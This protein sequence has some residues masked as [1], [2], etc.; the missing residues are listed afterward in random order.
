MTPT[1]GRADRRRNRERLIEA[2]AEVFRR[3]GPAAPLE[4]IARRAGVGSATLHRH[5]GS[6]RDLLEAVCADGI[7]QLCVRAGEFA[8]GDGDAAADLWGWLDELVRFASATRGVVAVLLT[9]PE[10]PVCHSSRLREVAGPLRS[11]AAAAGAVHPGATVDD[12]LAV[13]TGISRVTDDD[14]EAG[15][16]LLGLVRAGIG[17]QRIESATRG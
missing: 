6:R 13:V 12:L 16:R 10:L 1:T 8:A 11:R 9:E 7:D 2:A 17:S 5:F 14:P 3:D 15:S 4:E